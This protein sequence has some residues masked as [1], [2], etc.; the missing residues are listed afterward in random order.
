MIW[1]EENKI[2]RILD[3][4][5]ASVES[6]D[7]IQALHIAK[8]ELNDLR[9][10]EISIAFECDRKACDRGM[11]CSYPNCSHTGDPAHAVN[12]ELMGKN[13]LFEKNRCY[14]AEQRAGDAVDRD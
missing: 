8:Q 9:R 3:R 12:F 14:R 11:T 6:R 13:M 7:G 10:N 1:V 2:R 5:M 4:A